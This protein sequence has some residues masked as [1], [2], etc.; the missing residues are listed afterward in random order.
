GRRGV[1]SLGDKLTIT[2]PANAIDKELKVTIEKMVGIHNLMTNQGV[3]VSPIFEI[4]KNYPENFNKPVTLT[5]LF[6]SASLMSNQKASVF[7]YNEEKKSWVEVGGT[8]NSNHISVE[9]N[10]F[11][12]YTVLAVGQA[13][14][15]SFSDISN[16]WAE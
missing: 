3:L 13:Q 1:V 7:Y 4:L 9:V 8:V 6:D 12:T 15:V 11:G 5:F 2:I 10:H 14:E 16:H